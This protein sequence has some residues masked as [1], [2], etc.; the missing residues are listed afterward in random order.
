MCVC[1][2][3]LL[4]LRQCLLSETSRFTWHTLHWLLCFS[5]F[6]KIGSWVVPLTG[7]VTDPSA[8][9]HALQKEKRKDPRF[10]MVMVTVAC[11][12][13]ELPGGGLREPWYDG[14]RPLPAEDQIV[15]LFVSFCAFVCLSV[16]H[17]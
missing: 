7:S 3:E 6:S 11:M 9:R 5:C 14:P 13:V 16:L 10:F 12:N 4:Y 1:A 8:A 17:R 15:S 2:H